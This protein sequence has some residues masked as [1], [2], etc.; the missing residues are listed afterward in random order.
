M[1]WLKLPGTYICARI[2][3]LHCLG[4]MVTTAVAAENTQIVQPEG[5][6]ELSL[7]LPG[8]KLVRITLLQTAIADNFSYKD[9]LLWGGDV[10]E[11]P[12]TVMSLINV[13][14]NNENVF[15]PFSAYGDLGDL[16]LVSV[17]S[18]AE[19]FNLQLH[20]G[21]TATSYDAILKFSRTYILSR[22][23][24]LREFPRQ[25]LERTIYRFP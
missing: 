7:T 15:V 1:N 23:V 10:G 4:L 6:T 20:G 3:L 21:Y 18:T 12:K 25:R 9:A 16:R 22:T 24:T 17:E 19:G 13:H 5:R 8:G 14:I 11:I 2:V